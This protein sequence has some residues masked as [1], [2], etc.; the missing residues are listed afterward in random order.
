MFELVVFTAGEQ[1]YAD[2]ILDFMDAD[3]TIIKH[4]LYRQHCVC[5]TKGIYVKDLRIISDRD[6]KDIIIVDNSIVSF[7]YHLSNGIPIAAFTGEKNDE[8]LLFLVTYLEEL[9]SQ[10]DVRLHI[11]KT[12]KL[13]SMMQEFSY[14]KKHQSGALTLKDSKESKGEEL[15]AAA[16]SQQAKDKFGNFEQRD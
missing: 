16:S 11:D 4:R 9:F 1:D 2:T 8:E 7:A 14:K 15:K 12:F 3:R 10:H 6:M 5:P 13:T